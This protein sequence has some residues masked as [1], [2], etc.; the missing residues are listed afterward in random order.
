MSNQNNIDEKL[1]ALIFLCLDHG[2]DSIRDIE[3]P[4]IPY[5]ITEND[6]KR[7]LD[8]FLSDRVED[9]VAAAKTSIKNL[10]PIPEFAAITYDGYVTVE[11]E[12]YDAVIVEGY[13]R[14]DLDGH[15]FAQRYIPVRNG[16]AFQT[17]GNTIYLGVT[18]NIMKEK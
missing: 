14:K 10:D 17:P 11:N 3:G 15:I 1:L 6:G 16:T 13:D 18:E 7:N 9:G 2:I 12:K 8:R 4:L 5:S